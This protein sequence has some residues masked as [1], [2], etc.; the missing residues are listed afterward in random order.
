[1]RD[2]AKPVLSV[3][4]PVYRSEKTLRA[5]VSSIL[6]QADDAFPVEVLL[7]ANGMSEEEEAVLLCHKLAK[8]DPR[9]RVIYRKEGGVSGA[10]NAGIEA[11]SGRFIRFVDSDDE[12]LPG[13]LQ[14]M[15]ERMIKDGSTLLVAGYDHRY[16]CK[17]TTKLPKLSGSYTVK[18]REGRDVLLSLY[19]TDFLNPPWNKLYDRSLLQCRF[20]ENLDLGEDYLFNLDVLRAAERISVM[21]ESV[22]VYTQDGDGKSLSGSD[23][24]DRIEICLS[25]YKA[26]RTFFAVVFGK[27]E[28]EKIRYAADTKVVTTFL[29][30]IGLLG[31]RRD[32][33]KER[34]HAC[35]RYCMAIKRFR[36]SGKKDIRLTGA[37]RRILFV[38][39]VRGM[40]RTTFLLASLRGI[41]VRKFGCRKQRMEGGA[42]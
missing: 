9:I 27:A 35:A 21:K 31:S 17:K 16:F 2:G 6:A 28:E 18:S 33:E 26:T 30:E 22:Y 7:I 24:D 12:I 8:E 34:M 38:P 32:H 10:R 13:S 5:C 11:A 20:D 41:V 19:K 40:W 15:T 23:R 37:D 42:N 25:L 39:A 29:D 1:M 14:K 36:K 4:V 3:I